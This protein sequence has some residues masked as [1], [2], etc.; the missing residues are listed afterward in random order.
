M[1]DA[2]IVVCFRQD[3]RLAD[4]PALNAAVATGQPL[5]LCYVHDDTS[6]GDWAMGGA[7]R[8]WLHHSLRS[9]AR[10]ITTRGA[11]L[12][13]REGVW[14]DTVAV[15]ARSV[16]ADAV[17]WTRGYEPWFIRQERALRDALND[18]EVR[19][20]PGT[21]LF[22]PEDVQTGSGGPYKVFTPFWK[23]CLKKPAPADARP[24]PKALNG[25]DNPPDSLAL[26]DL[27]LLPTRPDWAG[28]LRDT[29]SPGE[30]GAH[31]RLNDFTDGVI[32][33]YDDARN[34]PG[35]DGTSMLSPHLHFG[36]LSPRQ[37]WH[38]AH[39]ASARGQHQRGIDV[40][41]SEIGW[42]E[43]SY[44]LLVHWPTLPEDPFREQFA[45]FRWRQDGPSLRSWQR[46]QTGMPIVDAGM[47]QL[48]HTGWMHNRVRM[49]VASLLV[50]NVLIHWRE[51]EDWFWDTLV[52]ADL[53]SN[54][55]GWQWVAGSG[56]DA[57]PYFRIFNPVTQSAKF[58]P[59]GDYLR[60]WVPEIAGLDKKHIHDPSSAPDH[61]LAAAGITLGTT[62]PLAIVDLKAT[63]QRALD[64]YK[65]LRSN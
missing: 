27:G 22:E 50:K 46:G 16:G 64:T 30:T 10:D 34:L 14:S 42:R 41:L 29:W 20:F 25:V 51:G 52:D 5:V 59:N 7:S 35:V 17:Y 2:P 54:A 63:R 18:I 31:D 43:F 33:D 62:Y 1:S 26:E 44:H 6:P 61:V 9:L 48:W 65:A 24:A 40:F 12:T 56:A 49:I 39:A 21:L 3:L 19:R 13:L 36:E 38:A 15:L 55:A 32:G 8:W 28:G 4:H 57:A 37:V 11:T 47:R 45:A 60:R 53:A 58:D 23:A